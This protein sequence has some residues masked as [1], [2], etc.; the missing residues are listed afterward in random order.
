M[1]N[2]ERTAELL[3]PITTHAPEAKAINSIYVKHH[4]S[5]TDLKMQIL[6]PNHTFESEMLGW[7]SDQLLTAQNHVSESFAYKEWVPLRSNEL[8]I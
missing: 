5:V 6:E 2:S 8:E 3:V 7:G 4:Q 1:V